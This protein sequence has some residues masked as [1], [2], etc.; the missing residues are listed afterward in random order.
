MKKVIL[1]SKRKHQAAQTAHG[2]KM[3]ALKD[4]EEVL[5]IEISKITANNAVQQEELSDLQFM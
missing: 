1:Q 5:K 3:A 2:A 4:E